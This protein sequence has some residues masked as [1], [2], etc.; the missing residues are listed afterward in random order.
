[1]FIVHGNHL[2]IEMARWVLKDHRWSTDPD[3]LITLIQKRDP[4]LTSVYFNFLDCIDLHLSGVV[5]TLKYIVKET[6]LNKDTAFILTYDP[7]DI[8][9]ATVVQGKPLSLACLINDL[10]P[11]ID[12][13]KF[14][15]KFL[16]LNQRY[17]FYRLQMSK[18]IH[19]NFLDQSI[20]SCRLNKD[21]L[22]SELGRHVLYFGDLI[23]WAEL[24]LPLTIPTSE[25]RRFEVRDS[26]ED[27]ILFKD[28]YF[29]EVVME[30][31][32]RS[33][34]IFTEKTIRSF[35]LGKPFILFS[36]PNSLRNLHKMGF[37]TFDG[38][39]DERYDSIEN[40]TERFIFIQTEITRLSNYS[41]DELKHLANNF[42]LVFEYNQNL[43]KE[44]KYDATAIN[45]SR[46]PFFDH[47]VLQ[48]QPN[49]LNSISGTVIL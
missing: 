48:S 37:K 44:L 24:N 31:N 26:I 49:N 46:R 10:T 32:H 5:L 35:L 6:N 18:F 47:Q 29:I 16:S 14:S 23:N 38:I 9:Y 36:G 8:D 3:V 34:H 28:E 13:T 22:Y 43:I 2:E 11:T 39:V 4:N 40:T 41:I 27:I 42:S 21:T 12:N 7:L 30:T 1:M 45:W 17:S 25:D 15:K 33:S 19:D 20:I